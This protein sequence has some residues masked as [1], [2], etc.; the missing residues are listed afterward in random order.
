MPRNG[1]GTYALPAGNPVVS[2][3]TISSTVHNATNTDIATALTGSL[4]KDG[5]TTPT[6]NQPMGSF[7]HTGVG[8]P[9]A[10]NQYATASGVQDGTYVFVNSVTG[11]NTVA[12]SLAPVI[13]AYTAGMHVVLVPANANTAAATLNLNG[14][15]AL[16]IQKYTSAGQVALAAN[17]L[18][19]GIPA[20][21]ILDTG[22]DDWI[23]LN[24]YSGSLGDVTVGT[25][26]ATT[27]SA[28]NATLTNING[29]TAP[30]AANPTGTIG[31]SVV[32]GT[33]TTFLRSD[34][35]PA[36]SQSITPTMT[37]IWTFTNAGSN[38]G[39]VVV[40]NTTPIYGWNET[41]GATDEKRWR[42]FVN[43][44]LWCVGT[45]TDA[46]GGGTVALAI[47][48]TGTT[49]SSIALTATALTWNGNALLSSTSALNADNVTGGTAVPSNRI[50]EAS[51]TQHQGAIKGRNVTGLASTAVTVQADPGGTPSGSAGALFY[52][53]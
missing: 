45:V 19:A 46:D 48:R 15:G 50:S 52:Y 4:S 42:A 20:L 12:G 16:D 51:V 29:V 23:L 34:G 1:S 41:D 36:L 28:T 26:T 13:T 27:V 30:A 9:T 35:A 49:P 17:D 6:A 24:P 18:R 3:T 31:L 33:A 8:D 10:R 11:T 38:T 40:T 32:N 47:D 22:G 14:A 53:Y 44:G 21:L 2:G 43:G 25:L 5:Q 7:R 37:G 39:A